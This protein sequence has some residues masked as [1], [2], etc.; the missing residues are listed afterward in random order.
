MRWLGLD[1]DE[2]PEVGGDYG[3]YLQTERLDTYRDAL[4]KLKERGQVYPCFCTKEE[5]DAKRAAAQEAGVA[6]EGYDRTC[7]NIDPDEAA[8]RIA[9]GEPH[10]WRLK[11]PLDH[12]PVEFDD[13]VLGHMSF[14]IEVMDDMVLVRSDGTPMYNFAVVCDDTNMAITH[15]IRGGDHVSNT[16]RQILIYE[17][18]GYP[19]PT[20]AHLSMINGSD[21]KKL[22]KRHGATSVE[23]YRDQGCLPEALVNYLA[24]LGWAPRRRDHHLLG[25]GSL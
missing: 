1:W 2:G 3:P 11:V 14:P 4:E 23:Q 16:P 17:A 13:A 22:S 21:S 25:P 12:G 7:R 10:V 15:V 18:L 9:A 6:Y 19:V 24:L 20:F 5:L 8:A